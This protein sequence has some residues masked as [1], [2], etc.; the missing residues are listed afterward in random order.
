MTAGII[1]RVEDQE[2]R[3]ALRRAKIATSGP[4]MA[5][6]LKSSVTRFLQM[7]ATQR[8]SNQGTEST[9][10]APLKP[11]TQQ[12]RAAQGFNPHFPINVRTGE[13]FRFVIQS[14]GDAAAGPNYAQLTW[15]DDADGETADKYETAQEGA[16]PN[17]PAR[18]VVELTLTDAVGITAILQKQITLQLRA[19]G[20]SALAAGEA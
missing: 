20:L 13:L 15:P 12:F 1:V 6:V 7:R 17:T 14:A 2:V 10:W 5:A 18:P 8:F 3:G 9:P 4:A 19:G 11:I 16:D